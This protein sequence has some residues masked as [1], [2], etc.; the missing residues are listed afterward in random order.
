MNNEEIMG[1]FSGMFAE[2]IKLAKLK[3]WICEAVFTTERLL[4]LEKPGI[5]GR[6][7][8]TRHPIYIKSQASQL[9]KLRKKEIVIDDMLGNS[10][11]DF[12]ISY[13]DIAAVEFGVYGLKL[14]G[15]QYIR[16]DIYGLLDTHVP[17]Y[18]FLFNLLPRYWDFFRGFIKTVLPGK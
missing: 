7:G 14:A 8:A 5:K 12:V 13:G 17:E 2:D 6:L 10:P 3:G 16:L 15:N 1:I 9:E 4:V 18:Q 11:K